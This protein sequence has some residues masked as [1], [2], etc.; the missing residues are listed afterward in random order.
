MKPMT[1]ALLLLLLPATILAQDGANHCNFPQ[2]KNQQMN[3]ATIRRLEMGWTDAYLR[4]DSTF[5]SCLLGPDFT[6][7]MRSGELKT[8]SDELAMAERNRG[9]D[10]KM[11]K[12]PEILVLL[13]ENVAIAYGN[14]IFEDTGGKKETRWYSDTYV[15]KDGQWHAVFAQQTAAQIR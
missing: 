13:H 9:K 15:W 11:S 7:I 4:G 6:E 3:T 8:V 2:L 1:I 12:Q 10:L 5:I 14:T